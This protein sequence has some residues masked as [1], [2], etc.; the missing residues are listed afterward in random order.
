LPASFS[1]TGIAPGTCSTCHN[2]TTATGKSGSHFV[3]TRSCDACHS[4]TAWT[5]TLKY[6]H[7]T[8]YYRQH[9]SGV[10]CANCHTSNNEIIAWKYG[11]YKPDC[12]GCHANRFKADSH[13]KTETPTTVLYTVGEL[14]DCAGSCHL[15]TNNTFTT[16][17]TNRSGH[18][19]STDGGF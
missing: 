16:I 19:R 1:H 18:H 17:K 6:S 12:A 10:L 4:T 5:P 11:T 3:T 8:P 9:N 14:K 13:K 2:G 7:T 15:Y